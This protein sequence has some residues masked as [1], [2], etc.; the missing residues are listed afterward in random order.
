VSLQK[1]AIFA[2][3]KLNPV[4]CVQ[5]IVLAYAEYKIIAQQEKTKRREIDAWE[6]VTITKINAQRDLLM[7]Y[8]DKSFDERAE[9]FRALFAV[10]D[11]AIASGNNEQLALTLNSITE[12]AKSS[13]FKE[14]A[15]LASVR[16]ALDDPNHEW[17]F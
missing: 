12:I 8:L 16:A 17:T 10:V 7:A 9:N 5:Q 15:N 2:L 14:L 6:K 1:I 13:P 4:E 3:D 11:S